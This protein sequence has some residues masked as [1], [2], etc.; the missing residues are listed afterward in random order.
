MLMRTFITSCMCVLL[1]ACSGG[2]S[3][4]AVPERQQSRADAQ[5]AQPTSGFDVQT[6]RAALNAG[7]QL[8]YVSGVATGS[9]KGSVDVYLANFMGRYPRVG[10]ITGID[11]PFELAIDRA[12]MLYV[13]QNDPGAPILVF[14]FA[15]P[16]P[17]LMLD[18]NGADVTSVAPLPNATWRPRA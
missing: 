9:S 7:V 2:F 3:P 16:H 4:P 5:E 6:I 15:S 8:L 17:S 13:A 10:R 11:N 1:A 18:T 12:G 14:P